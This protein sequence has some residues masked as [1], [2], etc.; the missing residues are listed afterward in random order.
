MRPP[1]FPA[2][3]RS[4]LALRLTHPPMSLHEL[5]AGA[6]RALAQDMTWQVY[7]RLGHITDPLLNALRMP[8][9]MEAPPMR[10]KRLRQPAWERLLQFTLRR[11]LDRVRDPHGA[12]YRHVTRAC[13]PVI[14]PVIE[15]IIAV[16]AT[17]SR[18]EVSAHVDAT[19]APAP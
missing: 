4:S 10:A 17:A 12:V 15:P 16:L 2:R 11:T 7:R 5:P 6:A 18:E 1:P 3:A 14:Q 13:H 8:P 9:V 19:R